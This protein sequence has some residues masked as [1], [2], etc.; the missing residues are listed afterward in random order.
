MSPGKNFSYFEA[1]KMPGR[2]SAYIGS[3]MF[4][5]FGLMINIQ[6]LRRY[7]HPS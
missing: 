4:I 5:F 2:V 3:C 1:Q 6:L 7:P